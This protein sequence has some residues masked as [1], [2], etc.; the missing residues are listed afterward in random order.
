MRREYPAV[1]YRAALAALVSVTL[2]GAAAATTVQNADPVDAIWKVQHLPFEYRS[3]ETFYSCDAL[4]QKVRAILLVAGAHPSL[5]ITAR[6][7]SGVSNHIVAQIAVATAVAA[8]PENIAAATH[9]DTKDELIAR[10]HRT[11]LPDASSIPHFTASWRDQSLSA[12]HDV[13]IT[14][15]DCELLH[16]LEEQILS[17]IDVHIVQKRPGCSRLTAEAGF[18]SM[19]RPNIRL[20]ALIPVPDARL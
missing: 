6:C 5:N 13:R 14:L 19:G 12:I 9:F 17:H 4:R 1:L 20:R 2:A 8:T 16:D 15:A 18:A 7:G 3:S 11:Q 10:L